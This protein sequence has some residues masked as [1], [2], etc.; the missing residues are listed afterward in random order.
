[1]PK[2]TDS[3][4]IELGP[5]DKKSNLQT[6]LQEF[7]NDRWD[8]ALKGMEKIIQCASSRNQFVKLYAEMNI[9]TNRLVELIQSPR[10]FVRKSSC[11]G[12]GRLFEIMKY[13]KRPVS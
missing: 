12:S 5:S 9:I 1:M 8:L 13:V 3:K 2:E 7:K 6:A 4:F 11:H 10:S